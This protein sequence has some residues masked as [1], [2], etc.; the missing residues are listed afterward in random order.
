M[1]ADGSA[2]D[3]GGGRLMAV[4]VAPSSPVRYK[5][6]EG[7]WDEALLPGGRP[8]RHWRKLWVEVGRLG[9]QQLSRRWQA[10][11]Q[12]LQSQGVTYN[13]GDYPDG[14]EHTWP[15]DP[16]PLVIDEREWDGIER[17]I[18]QRA[19][20]LNA[21]L[22]D[23]YGAS[24]LVRERLL[25]SALVYD[26]PHFLRPCFGIA[27]RG[28]AHLHT[29]AA[30]IA[31]APDGRWWVVADRT[32]APSGMGYTLQNRLVS[33]RSL[34]GVFNQC[35]VRQLARFF[36]LKREALLSA[37][38]STRS[39]PTV[40]LITPGPRNETYFEH[41]FLAGQWGFTLVEGA[42]LIVL[43]RRVYMK[44]LGGLKPVDVILRRLDDSY[45]DPL[46][47][48]GDSLLG[49]AGLVDAVRSGSVVIDNALGSGLVETAAHM[50]FLPGLCRALLGQELHMP[51]VATW[52]CGHEEPRRYVLEHLREL[53]VKSAF[54]RP[55]RHPAFPESM[56]ASER[57]DLARKIEAAPEEYV[58]QERVALSTVPARTESGFVPRHAMLRVYAAWTG[59]GYTVMPGGLTRVSTDDSSMIVSMQLGGGS[60]DTWVLGDAEEVAAGRRQLSLPIR[61]DRTR[62]DLPSRVADNLF[63]LGRYTERVETAVRLVRALLPALSGEEDYGRSVSLDTAARILAG[64]GYLPRE[65]VSESLGEQ[66]WQVQR[67]LLDM[68]YDSTQTSSLRWNLKELRRTSWHLKERLSA[69]TWRVMQQL[70][71]QFSGFVPSSADHR[72]LAGMDLLDGA[73][74]TLSAFSGLLTENTTRGF[75]WRFLEIGRRLERALQTAELLGSALTVGGADLEPYLQL[76]LQVADSSITYRT[77]YPTALQTELVL[78]VLWTDESNPRAVSFQ[79]TTLLA[80][81]DL[82]EELEDPEREGLERNLTLQAIGIVRDTS[83]GDLAQR[84]EE[85]RYM[86]L[87]EHIAQ[88]RATLHDLSDTLSV[89][90]L[91]PLRASRLTSLW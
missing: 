37:A 91:S 59:D 89:S 36:D 4:D 28:G 30:D 45:C 5:G 80:Q 2:G 90:Y 85:G 39:N 25:P 78:D 16:I 42:D 68:I 15:M 79:L 83:T 26:N 41:S 47:L 44:T 67:T 10:G 18:G 84:D 81:L 86:V 62:S 43:D 54:P 52:W 24:R 53:V 58:A 1:A 19:T 82:V 14:G 72:V 17:A 63:W 73:I 56:S 34:P 77:R 8:R 88:L 46:E 50:A 6:I 61:V 20:L 70:E 71:N 7:Y 27:P 66:R 23:L 87:D 60:K 13:R 69:D 55:G 31:R 12:L 64:L 40:A 65:I 74:V 48:R 22:A 3:R 75:G 35:R 11:Q 33:A 32:Q 49:V 76:L 29:Y 21:I 38:S 57:T 51:S 9:F